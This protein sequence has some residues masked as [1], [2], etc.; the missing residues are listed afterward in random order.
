M[1]EE[2]DGG[3]MERQQGEDIE[4]YQ[5]QHDRLGRANIIIGIIGRLGRTTPA[6]RSV[7]VGELS[8]FAR[9]IILSTAMPKADSKRSGLL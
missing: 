3:V 6:R 5:R 4:P 1:L 7:S 8:I 2:S 9:D